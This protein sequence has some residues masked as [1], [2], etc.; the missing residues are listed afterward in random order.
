[1][2]ARLDYA[3]GGS[4]AHN[5]FPKERTRHIKTIVQC[6]WWRVRSIVLLEKWRVRHVVWSSL[7]FKDSKA[8]LPYPKRPV[9][10]S[11]PSQMNPVH[12]PH[13]YSF[14]IH[15]PTLICV[16]KTVSSFGFSNLDSVCT[17]SSQMPATRPANPMPLGL[18]TVIPFDNEYQSW[19]ISLL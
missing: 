6:Y 10:I 15:L 18:I 7:N 12:I 2:E 9:I 8:S 1:M 14:N 16:S 3:K 5:S 19:G 17:L 13:S 4:S 11:Y